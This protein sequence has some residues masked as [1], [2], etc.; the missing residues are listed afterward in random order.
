MRHA[1]DG[2][3]VPSSPA[4]LR[5]CDG[6]GERI[7]AASTAVVDQAFTPTAIRPGTE[8]SLSDDTQLLVALAVGSQESDVVGSVEFLLSRINGEQASLSGPVTRTEAVRQFRA[9]ILT[10]TPSNVEQE[11]GLAL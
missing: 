5:I 8:I 4:K 11:R 1:K 2:A 7:M 6:K 10:A 9:F 3:A